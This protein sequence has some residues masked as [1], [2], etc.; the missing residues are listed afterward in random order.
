VYGIFASLLLVR[1]ER[2]LKVKLVSEESLHELMP[3]LPLC[4]MHEAGLYPH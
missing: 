4:T 2:A 3:A 1:L